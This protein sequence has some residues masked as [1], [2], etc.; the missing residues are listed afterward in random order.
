M[1]YLKSFVEMVKGHIVLLIKMLVGILMILSIPYWKAQM[2]SQGIR[3][4]LEDMVHLR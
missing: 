4:G 1:G 2:R 3:E